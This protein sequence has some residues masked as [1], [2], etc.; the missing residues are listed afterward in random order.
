MQLDLFPQEDNDNGEI[1]TLFCR[2]C[3][4]DRPLDHFTPSAVTYETEPRPLASRAVCGSARYCRS[5]S[6]DYNKGSLI[7]KKMAPP[8][9]RESISCECCG[10]NVPAKSIHL[11]HCHI[12]YAFRGW[13]CRTCNVGLGSLGDNIEGLQRAINYLNR[14]T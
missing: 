6:R 5:C 9:P 7:A 13:L 3:Q 11:D 2:K 14:N 8:R 10:V 1:T 4:T 12:T